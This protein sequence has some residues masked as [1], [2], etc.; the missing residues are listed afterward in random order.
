MIFVAV[1]F[2]QV[3]FAT[4]AVPPVHREQTGGELSKL[5]GTVLDNTT[6]EPI[7]SAIV[8]LAQTRHS[9]RSAIDGQFVIED[10]EPGL[11]SVSVSSDQYDYD[12]RLIFL[13]AGTKTFVD[14][15]PTRRSRLLASYMA[16][17]Q[18]RLPTSTNSDASS[19]FELQTGLTTPSFLPSC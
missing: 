5:Q 7:T 9:A 11:Y 15:R 8:H 17:R 18:F 12:R 4:I 14:L 19:L 13:P 16:L 6:G 10:I 1:I 2:I 3:F